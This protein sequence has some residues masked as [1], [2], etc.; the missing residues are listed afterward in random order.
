MAPQRLYITKKFKTQPSAVKNIANVFWDSTGATH[1]YLLPPRATINAQ[2]YS[3]FLLN[4][5]H[6][7]IRKKIPGKLSQ[8]I[9][10]LHEKARFHTAK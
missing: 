1:V 6:V 2:Y 5:V 7:A 3:S 10:L 8:G 4:D 9:I